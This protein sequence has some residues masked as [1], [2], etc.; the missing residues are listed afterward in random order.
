MFF[1]KCVLDTC[2]LRFAPDR[3]GPLMALGTLEID[4]KYVQIE[5]PLTRPDGQGL[6][7]LESPGRGSVPACFPAFV[8]CSIC[9]VHCHHGTNVRAVRSN[10]RSV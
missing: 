7:K 3:R 4:L 6:G 1:G 5:N 8:K 10:H 9:S 2:S